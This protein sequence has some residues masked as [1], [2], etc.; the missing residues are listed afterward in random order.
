M[1]IALP[2]LHAQ[3]HAY[4]VLVPQREICPFLCPQLDPGAKHC[5]TNRAPHMRASGSAVDM[6]Y[7]TSRPRAATMGSGLGSSL[8]TISWN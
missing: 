5:E 2:Y 7:Y 4:T 6:S 3:A 8:S 1:D